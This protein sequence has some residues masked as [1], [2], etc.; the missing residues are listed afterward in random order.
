ML[1]TVLTR[2]RQ[3]VTSLISN[4]T[5]LTQ[6]LLSKTIGVLT[7]IQ[8]Q[9][10]GSL[11]SLLSQCVTTLQKLKALLAQFTTQVSL[12]KSGI[13]SVAHSLIQIGQQLVTTVRQT[14]QHV[15]SV[16]KKDK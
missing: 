9:F 8:T 3:K 10:V 1:G 16:F 15:M 14:L 7:V 11:T 12:I 6:Q 5:T 2:L 4:A 13:I